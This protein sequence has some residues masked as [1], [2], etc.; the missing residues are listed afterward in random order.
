MGKGHPSRGALLWLVGLSHCGS[1]IL[2]I[3][4]CDCPARK[5]LRKSLNLTGEDVSLLE[6]LSKY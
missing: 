3:V 1:R 5:R 4:L 2:R 6:F